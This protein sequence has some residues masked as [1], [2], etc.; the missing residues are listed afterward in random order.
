MKFEVNTP[1]MNIITGQPMLI[2]RQTEEGE[3][4]KK[5][6]L[7]VG[8]VFISSLLNGEMEKDLNGEEKFTRWAIANKVR[9]AMT[10]GTPVDLQAEDIVLIKQLVAKSYYSLV[11]GWIYNYLA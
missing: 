11:S 6:I 2:D 9:N 1:V 10:E 5:E 7:L 4:P 3:P 8:D